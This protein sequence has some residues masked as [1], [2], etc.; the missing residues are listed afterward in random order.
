M[1]EYVALTGGETDDKKKELLWRRLLN[2]RD[3]C[4]KKE[5]SPRRS[6]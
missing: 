4:L 5:N 6:Q 1:G 2:V 3:Y